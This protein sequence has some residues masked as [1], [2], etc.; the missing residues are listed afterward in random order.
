MKMRTLEC[1]CEIAASGFSFSRAAR[2]L[3]ATQPAVT[4]Q[5]QLL[6]RELGFAVFERRGS[7]AIRLTLAGKNAL[8]RAQKII[9]E[10]REMTQIKDDLGGDTG[11]KLTVA[12]TEFNAR[13]T[14]LPAIKKFRSKYPRVALSILSVD[15]RTAAQLVHT[16]DADFG[17]CTITSA[18]SEQLLSYKCFDVDRIVVV[19]A[20]HP[21]T[22]V[23]S[24]SL[25]KIAAYPL[26]VY[27]PL[28]SGGKHVLD[29]FEQNGIRIQIALSAM[30]ADV[31]KSYVSAGLGIGIIQS[32]AFDK[33]KDAG[34]RALDSSKIFG[35]TSVFLLL[36]SG[37]SPRTCL[38]EFISLLAPKL[39]PFET[40]A[41]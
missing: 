40:D 8:E 6:E 39:Q 20:K 27:D 36:R 19:P 3:N 21:L 28:L 38:R 25:K 32:R 10:T 15:P 16:G 17:L 23:E 1:F 5:I 9:N 30:T 24:L 35:P 18:A 7:K 13:Y 22:R 14:L 33:Q 11:G 31:I 4:R 41:R 29:A 2:A 34:L 26:I 37:L 12:T